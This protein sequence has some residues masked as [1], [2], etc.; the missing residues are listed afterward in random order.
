MALSKL[1]DLL[2][3][4]MNYLTQRQG[5]IG[6]NIANASTPGYKPKDLQSFDAVLKSQTDMMNAGNG[7][8]M[9]VTNARHLKGLRGGNG[10][11][12]TE[13][14]KDTYETKPDGNAVVM[15]QQMT[16]LADTN[17]QYQMITG[18]YKKSIGFVKTALS[19]GN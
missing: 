19:K 18:L 13:R 17:G 16:Q 6:Q 14:M 8:A 1:F 11:F 9:A 7:L 15:E 3:T 12:R 5:V 10:G 2:A 4:K